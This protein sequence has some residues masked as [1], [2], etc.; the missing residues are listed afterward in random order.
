MTLVVFAAFFTVA[1]AQTIQPSFSDVSHVSDPKG[2]AISVPL[3]IGT[4][5][6]G[7][8]SLLDQPTRH[9]I[10]DFIK[11]NPGMHF[12]GICES[13]DLSV[14]VVQYHLYTLERG[15]CIVSFNDG[16]NKRFFQAGMFTQQEMKLVSL[17][18]HPTA[19]QILTML[20][21]NST[22][23]HRDIALNLGVSSQALTWQ[24]NQLKKAD[25][26]YAQKESVNV[27]YALTCPQAVKSA[28]GLISINKV[29][30]Q[31]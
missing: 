14:G 11:A 9:Q 3:V 6:Q 20:T 27:K 31:Y 28:L 30:E 12:R 8:S 10:Y 23:L 15:G 4:G 5:Y 1:Y 25:L 19:A 22:M 16:Q 24:M 18:R 26:I 17:A 21:E 7:N 29:G 13:L 2:L